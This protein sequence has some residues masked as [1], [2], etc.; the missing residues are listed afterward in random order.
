MEGLM[1]DPF[2]GEI[3]LFAGTYAPMYWAFCWGQVLSIQSNTALFSLIGATYGGNGS[4]TFALPDL[5]SRVPV[6]QGP[7]SGS[8][9]VYPLGAMMGV[10]SVTLTTGE[11]PSHT[12][13]VPASTLE[14][15]SRS[16]VGTVPASTSAEAGWTSGA[17][18]ATRAVTSLAGG[19]QSHTNL[20]PFL[21]I[22]HIIC[23][24][25]IFPQRP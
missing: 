7:R 15:T 25:G 20:Q 10:E 14:A 17:A 3:R 12:H 18:N 9:E 19:S 6:S 22:H 16:A 2:T 5:R 13:A 21:G 24:N 1:G 11:M 4:S 8:A 23:L